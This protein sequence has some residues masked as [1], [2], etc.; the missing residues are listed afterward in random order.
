MENG[1]ANFDL[2]NV[3]ADESNGFDYCI[4]GNISY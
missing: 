3:L 2:A 4:A 1:H